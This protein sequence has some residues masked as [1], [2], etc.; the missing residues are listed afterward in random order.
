MF[1]KLEKQNDFPN[2]LIV[3]KFGASEIGLLKPGMFN[4][5]AK[6]GLLNI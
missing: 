3:Y 6:Y 1:P 2:D 4:F 5:T